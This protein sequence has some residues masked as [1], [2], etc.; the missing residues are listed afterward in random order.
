MDLQFSKLFQNA[1]EGEEKATILGQLPEWLFK[2][3]FRVIYNG[4][5]GIWDHRDGTVNHWFDGLSILVSLTISNDNDGTKCVTL[6]KR[7]L[8]SE[9]YQKALTHGKLISTEYA[10]AGNKDPDKGLMSSL[11]SSIIP[12][13]NN[14]N[15]YNN[16]PT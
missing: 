11:V 3:K 8:A 1:S 15:Y 2:E 16:I 9:A 6:K 5:T 4:P 13:N 12:G 14:K 10:T 7:F